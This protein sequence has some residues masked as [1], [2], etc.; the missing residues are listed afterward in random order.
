MIHVSSIRYCRHPAE[1]LASARATLCRLSASGPWLW[2][3]RSGALKE[4]ATIPLVLLNELPGL[5]VAFGEGAL[6]HG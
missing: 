3:V 1:A 6:G 5:L 2:L 4:T